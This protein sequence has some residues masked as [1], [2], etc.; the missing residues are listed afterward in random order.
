MAS[1]AVV[2]DD[3]LYIFKK[4]PEVLLEYVWEFFRGDFKTW[5]SFLQTCNLLTTNILLTW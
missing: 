5:A 3:F 2:E 4:L 1:L